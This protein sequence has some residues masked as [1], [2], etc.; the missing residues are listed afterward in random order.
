MKNGL[1]MAQIRVLL[2]EDNRLLRDGTT[3]MLNEQRDIRAVS[4]AGN[5]GALEKAGKFMPDVV[6]LDVGLRSR[7]SLKVL[8]SLKKRFPRT[9]VVVMDLIPVHS[10]V[11][12]FVKAGVSGFIPKDATLDKFLQTIR[13]VVKGVRILPPTMADSLF[14]RIVESAIQEGEVARVIA[15]S[16]LTKREQHVVRFLAKGQSVT[17]IAVSLRVTVFTVKSHVRNILDKLALHTRL[18]LASFAQSDKLT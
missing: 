3:A 15:A 18:E 14:S 17:E 5:S 8:E 9:E 6:L 16:K 12:A 10:E 13:A 4:S 1:I 11:A 7:N 2:I